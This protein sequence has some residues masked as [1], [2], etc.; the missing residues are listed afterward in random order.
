M[1][2]TSLMRGVI[3]LIILLILVGGYV[4][5]GGKI[6]RNLLSSV[7]P[8]ILLFGCFFMHIFMHGG[9]GNHHEHAGKSKEASE[10]K[11]ESNKSS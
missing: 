7:L 9:H 3:V 1:K 11:I 5:F 10:Q 8:F 4:V 2:N 6:D